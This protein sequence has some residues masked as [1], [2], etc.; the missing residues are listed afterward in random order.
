MIKH[1]VMWKLR[2]FAGG[3][4]KA[5][6]AKLLRQKLQDL[7][8]AIPE[9][10]KVE[11]GININESAAAWD[12][13]LYSEFDGRADLRA[14]QEHPLHQDLVQNFLQQVRTEKAVVDYES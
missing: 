2:D 14:Y 10:K 12:V 3:A 4:S 5:E 9:M 8:A 7:Q 11:V 6:N 1:I 13:V